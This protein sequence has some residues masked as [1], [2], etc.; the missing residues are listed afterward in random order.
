MML[1]EHIHQRTCSGVVQKTS[2]ANLLV[3]LLLTLSIGG[4]LI[5]LL[6]RYGP[7]EDANTRC[8]IDEQGSCGRIT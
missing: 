2:G 5:Y 8:L 3:V 1:V 6:L 7:R 4:A